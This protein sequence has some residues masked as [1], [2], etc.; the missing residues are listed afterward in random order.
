MVTRQLQTI[1][2][3]LLQFS[4]SRHASLLSRLGGVE[5]GSDACTQHIMRQD[6]ASQGEIMKIGMKDEMKDV[7]PVAL[8]FNISLYFTP[9]PDVKVSCPWGSG[10]PKCHSLVN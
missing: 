9:V 10:S 4:V 3:T 2:K 6:K 8:A 7:G 5:V 1:S